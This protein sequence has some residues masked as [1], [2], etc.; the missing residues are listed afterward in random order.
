MAGLTG[1]ETLLVLGQDQTGAPAATTFQTTTA[2]IAALAATEETGIVNTS[3]TTVGN[4]TLTAAG[5]VGGLITRT[6]PTGAY[7]DATDTAVAIVAALPGFIANQTFLIR[8]K[9]ATAFTQT[10]TA[11]AG[12]TLPLTVIIPAFSVGNYYAKVT[13]S[14]AVTLN[15]LN[16]VP[17][18]N[19]LTLSAPAAPALN[20]V[21]AG[22]IT[23]ALMIGGFTL[24][25]GAQSGAA[26]NDTTDTAA[27]IIAAQPGLVNKIG[28]AFLY[29]YVNNTN[30]T[31]TLIGG[32]GV[33]SAGT[34][35]VVPANSQLDLLIT[36]NAAATITMTAVGGGSVLLLPESSVTLATN[37]AGTVTAASIAARIINRTTVAAPFTDTTD[38]AANIVA[39]VPNAAAG[40]SFEAVYINGTVGICTL[41]G[42][43]GVNSAGNIT[44]IPA[45][46]SA[47]FLVTLTS[48]T[49][50]T[51]ALLSL[52]PVA[53][54][55]SLNAGA[56][57]TL[58]AAHS[59]RPINLNTLSGS[60]V[61]LPAATGSGA[62]FPIT[63]T[64]TTTS[65]AHKILAASSSDFIN[66]ISTGFT[67]STPKT[68]ASAAATNHSI[69]MPFAG[70]QPS[71]G[72]IGDT[73]LVVDSAANLWTITGNYQAGTTPT[74]PYSAATS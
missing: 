5:L 3:I 44:T 18:A 35:A 10:I 63:V 72:F 66:G 15:H 68:F 59:G 49:A 1:L 6:G 74:T 46:T 64:T 13:S 45:Q 53:P 30:A 9:N 60:V 70:S 42:G 17:I 67:G 39:A 71:G 16:T 26:F 27:N 62:T 65:G 41:N 22:T 28:T 23:A 8:I 47:R 34:I 4:G 69:Q 14:T 33:N 32:T 51:F 31:A 54:Q 7:S 38:T 50:V 29:T 20:T 58:T 37:G 36:Y 57:L 21:G 19:S 43:T 24:R 40:M 25:G 12:V 2:A 73:F 56:A 55:P 11:G 61:T 48:L 52:A